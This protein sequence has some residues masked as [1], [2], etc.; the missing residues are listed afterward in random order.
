MSRTLTM[1]IRR[2]VSAFLTCVG[3]L[4]C[5][6]NQFLYLDLQQLTAVLD[7]YNYICSNDSR[8]HGQYISN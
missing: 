8:K 1:C 2:Q 6:E 4:Q 7:G 5:P 3:S